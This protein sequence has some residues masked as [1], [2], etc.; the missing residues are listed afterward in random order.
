MKRLLAGLLILPFALILG[1]SCGQGD[2][3][4][5][6]PTAKDKVFPV[7]IASAAKR[8]IPN[9][10]SYE[11]QFIPLQRLEVKSDFTG[12]VQALSVVEG[13]AVLSGDVLLKIED[14]KL[15]W[16]LDRQRA[17][18]R[19]AEAQME[20]DSRLAN[21]GGQEDAFEE[22]PEQEEEEEEEEQ[23]EEDE[24]AEEEEE[25]LEE[26]VELSPQERLARLRRRAQ[27]ARARARANRRT[28]PRQ[29]ARPRAEEPVNEEVIESRQNL[30]QAKIDRIRAEITLTEK[31]INGATIISP[32]DGFVSRVKITE[33]SLVRSDQL[34]VDI[35]MVDPIDLSLKVPTNEIGKID[36]KMET[37]VTVPDLGASNFKGEISFIGAEL[38]A[39]Q[40]DVEVRIRVDNRG[41]KIKL[42][43][44]GV[45]SLAISKSTHSALL[46]PDNSIVRLE[47][48]SYVYVV[49]GQVAKR[50]PVTLGASYEGWTEI[51]KG[52]R[53]SDRVVSGGVQSLKESE[54]FIKVSG[55]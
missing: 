2:T 37:K 1:S 17:E 44:K 51:K 33:G 36:K 22:F 53:K 6:V 23:P 16:V 48:K 26:G 52:I 12:K 8:E 13:Q 40:R 27:R 15:P 30:H 46:V 7:T 38:G 9:V 45:A 32:F 29:A 24:V 19:E 34:L 18:L 35:V 11:G 47:E 10:L 21:G 50:V 39:S 25:E 42:G 3:K 49:R 55:V 41:E 28:P 5:S 31:Q 14:E 43:M 20:L 54:E 4:K